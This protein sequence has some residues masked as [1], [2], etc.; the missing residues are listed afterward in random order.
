MWEATELGSEDL[1][2]AT[3]NFMGGIAG[4]RECVCGV[5]SGAAVYLGLRHRVPLTDKELA[6]K[7]RLVSRGQTR[8]IVLSFTREFGNITCGGLVGIDWNDPVAVQ[9][10]RESGQWMAKCIGYVQFIIR[11]LYELEAKPGA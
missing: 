4:Q 11:R 8:D 7:A 5:I 2:W 10:Y 6:D 3:T 9:R 1:L